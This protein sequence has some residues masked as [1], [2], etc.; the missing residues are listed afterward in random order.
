M[1]KNAELDTH[2]AQVLE[3][4]GE[5]ARSLRWKQAG[6]SGLSL[7]QIRIL[8]FLNAHKGERIGVARLAEELQVSKPTISESVKLLDERGLVLRKAGNGDGRSHALV[9]SE[10]GRKYATE[11]T[12]M[13]DTLSQLD[14]STKEALLLGLMG[15][16]EA[17]FRSEEVQVQRL[18]FT[19]LHYQGDRRTKHKCLLLDRVLKVAELRSDCPEHEFRVS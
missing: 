1:G 13:I 11:A 7:L 16:L 3:R 10:R 19:C 14:T 5:I 17:L 18:C 9:L 6:E 15:V 2:V 8:G 4:I 12:P